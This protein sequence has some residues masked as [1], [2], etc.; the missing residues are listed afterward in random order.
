[1]VKLGL[2]PYYKMGKVIRF[3]QSDLRLALNDPTWK[4]FVEGENLLTMYQ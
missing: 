3:R 1:M 2:F 4:G